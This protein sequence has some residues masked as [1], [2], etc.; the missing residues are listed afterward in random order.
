MLFLLILVYR[1]KLFHQKPIKNLNFNMRNNTY[2]VTKAVI[3]QIRELEL[4]IPLPINF[5]TY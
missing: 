2:L 3:L 1:P 5:T 4:V